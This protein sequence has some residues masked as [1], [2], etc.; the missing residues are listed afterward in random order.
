MSGRTWLFG[1][2]RRPPRDRAP[3]VVGAVRR[4]RGDDA[5][6]PRPA[7]ADHVLFPPVL[8]A[9]GRTETI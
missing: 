5:A 1:F 3:T 8:A 9:F 4:A 2:A 6:R 7:A